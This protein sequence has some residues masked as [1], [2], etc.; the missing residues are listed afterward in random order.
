[1]RSYHGGK[2]ESYVLG[3][4]KKAKIIDITSAYPYALSKLPKLTKKV[5]YH[6]ELYY[7]INFYYAFIRCDII[8][9]NENFIHPVIVKI[10]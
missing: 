4:I 6:K 3:F 1:M 2:I 9:D 10:L 5:Q 8:I 7:L